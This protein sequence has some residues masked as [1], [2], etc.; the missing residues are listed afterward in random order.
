MNEMKSHRSDESLHSDGYASSALPVQQHGAE[1]DGRDAPAPDSANVAD[2]TAE[3][4]RPGAP[5]SLL[6]ESGL[7][8]SLES[9]YQ[10]GAAGP[11]SPEAASDPG[12]NHVSS[13]DARCS[14][15]RR[16]RRQIARQTQQLIRRA[17]AAKDEQLRAL[18]R[19]LQQQQQRT[20]AEQLLG[21]RG[22]LDR[23]RETIRRLET[24]KEDLRQEVRTYEFAN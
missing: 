13:D 23:L 24:E 14:E 4:G 7:C 10:E 19:Q 8:S 16:Q 6:C 18:R 20:A 11:A 5:D 2:P 12:V 1:T 3:L 17:I 21:E 15:M 22:Q 9:G